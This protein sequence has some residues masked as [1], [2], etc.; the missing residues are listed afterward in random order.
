MRL[1]SKN[2][3][4]QSQ[5]PTHRFAQ[6]RFDSADG[7]RGYRV[8]VAVPA[9]D[10]PVDG[11]PAI[12][13]LDGNAA[14][15]DLR[16]ADLDLVPGY[17]LIGIGYETEGRHDV[18]ARA[19]DYTP[20]VSPDAAPP[21]DSASEKE[22]GGDVFLALL[23]ERVLPELTKEF[24]LDPARRMLWGHSYGGLFVLNALFKQPDLFR[25]YCAVS[26]S[27]WWHAPLTL[28]MEGASRR[29]AAGQSDLLLLYEVTE[30]PRG[31]E[32]RR[33]RMVQ[34][35]AML[36]DMLERL[37]ARPDIALTQRAY[38]G[39]NHGSMFQVGLKA[40]LT[41]KIPN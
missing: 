33:A 8:F 35:R 19:Q 5:S 28:H 2:A 15:D 14:F 1:R 7:L 39:E 36:K 9:G 20:P 37:A 32:R 11:W 41:H 10:R 4:W 18:N 12:S 6:R 21:S 23:A 25:S 40:A 27:L 29:R 34:G 38:P 22:G 13:M 26:P 30:D 16:Q 31:D 3:L 17:A 24:S